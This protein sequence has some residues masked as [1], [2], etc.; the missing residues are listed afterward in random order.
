MPSVLHWLASSTQVC[1]GWEVHYISFS[2]SAIFMLL[3]TSL[4]TVSWQRLTMLQ[5]SFGTA[6]VTVTIIL[7]FRNIR[8]QLNA[9]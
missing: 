4:Q 6:I 5:Q 7:P 1:M 2:L 8:K 9:M 3:H